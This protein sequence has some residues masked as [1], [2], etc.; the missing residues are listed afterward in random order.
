MINLTIDYHDTIAQI[1]GDYVFTCPVR[2]INRAFALAGNA[3]IY[4]YIVDSI[5]KANGTL[6]ASSH[7]A[8]ECYTNLCHKSEMPFVFNL[9]GVATIQFTDSEQPFAQLIGHYWTNF[10]KTG[11]PNSPSSIPSSWN[12][13]TTSRNLSI[14]EELS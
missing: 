12:V 5:L 4:S 9:S 8:P 6:Y 7:W 2:N 14:L 10:E 3:N 11:D 1:L 13:F